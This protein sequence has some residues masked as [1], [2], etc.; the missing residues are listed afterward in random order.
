MLKIYLS[1]ISALLGLLII[2]GFSSNSHMNLGDELVLL[3]DTCYIK[4]V[5]P[6]QFESSW[7]RLP[8]YTGNDPSVK[9]LDYHR[10]TG[11]AKTKWVEKIDT[12]CLSDD[13]E[14]CKMY[15]FEIFDEEVETISYLADTINVRAFTY[16]LFEDRTLVKRGGEYAYQPAIC[17][18][19]L[20][21]ILVSKI[22]YKLAAQGYIA[23]TQ[24][25]GQLSEVFASGLNQ[26]QQDHNLPIG[27]V[28]YATLDK[29]RIRY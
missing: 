12:N 2:M 26:Y 3:K 29:L 16:K 7:T 19:K 20:N 9:L 25:N 13:P 11:E 15:C 24:C 8:I 27:G 18:D 22:C 23:R 17:T 28:N 14:D 5:M 1:V 6:D 21:D 10:K 4:A